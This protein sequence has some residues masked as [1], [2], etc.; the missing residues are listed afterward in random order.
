VYFLSASPPQIGRAIR[1]KLELDG[2]I[3]DGI[4]FKDQ[5]QRIMRGKFRHLREH[6]GYKLTELLKARVAE[7]PA[8]RE[9]LFGDDW[10][11]DPLTYSL[12]A[13]VVAGALPA[14]G[15][16]TVLRRIGVDPLVVPQLVALAAEV[17]PGGR[18]QRIFI[19]LARRS[20]PAS[21]RVFGPRLAPTFNYFQT[22]L[23]LG[24]M[25][26]LDPPDVAAVGDA[27]VRQ[28][29]YS[30]RRLANS[31]DDLVRRGLL[32]PYGA[33]RVTSALRRTQLLVPEQRPRVLER[34]RDW[35][36]D[37]RLRRR[38]EPGGPAL[39][40]ARIFE[41]FP[42]MARTRATEGKP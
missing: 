38:S 41:A 29:G 19:N 39:D 12:Y 42:N 15:L 13:D 3:Y 16:G 33:R 35:G 26:H 14:E 18:V 20:P 5:L 6:I 4:V 11:S 10:E 28:H 30:G 9:Y 31:L 17:R 37:I 23:V 34:L 22:A 21:L 7:P 40:Y 25:G 36:R 1:R 24:G 8:A 27:L 32:T 2:I